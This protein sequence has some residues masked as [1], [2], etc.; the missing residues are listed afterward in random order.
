LTR[1]IADNRTVEGRQ[2]NRR[3]VANF[4]CVSVEK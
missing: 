2:K 4:G 1:P 3:T